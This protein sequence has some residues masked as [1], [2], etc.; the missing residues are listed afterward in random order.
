MPSGN[1]SA[2]RMA[3]TTGVA[4][5]AAVGVGVFLVVWH[6]KTFRLEVDGA[7]VLWVALVT[8][9]AVWPAGERWSQAAAGIAGGMVAGVAAY[10]GAVVVLPVTA[11]GRG[12]GLGVA[13]A[14][15]GGVCLAGHRFVS[16]G[17]AMVGYGIGAGVSVFAGIRPTSGM[18][19]IFEV[20]MALG[21]AILAGVFG[22]RLLRASAAVAQRRQVLHAE[23]MHMSEIHMPHF[24]LPRLHMPHIRIPR[25]NGGNGHERVR[26]GAQR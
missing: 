6:A 16:M 18:G 26:G 15:V 24:H 22:A 8:F 4:I 9:G 10:Y 12:I 5:A 19:D 7:S 13:A 17:A 21:V 25:P 2:K 20:W 14:V 3:W 1:G 23:A 11:L